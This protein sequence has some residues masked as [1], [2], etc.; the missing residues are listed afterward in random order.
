MQ[1]DKWAG[2]ALGLPLWPLNG[3]SPDYQDDCRLWTQVPSAD[4]R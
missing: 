1:S 4:S 3:N 2:N